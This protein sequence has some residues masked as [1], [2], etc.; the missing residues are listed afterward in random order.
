MSDWIGWKPSSLDRQVASSRLRC[1]IPMAEL[2]SRGF[3]IE[4]FDPRHAHRYAAVVYSKTYDDASY[5][6]AVKLR[7]A[8]IRIIFDLCDNHFYNPQNLSYWKEARQR[9][10][11]MMELADALVVSS[12]ALAEV[13]KR[14]LATQCSIAVIGDPVETDLN[15]WPMANWRRWLAVRQAAWLCAKLRAGQEQGRTPLIWFGNHGSPYAEGGMLDLQ[16]LG[17]LLEGLNRRSPISLTVISNSRWKYQRYI[18]PWRIPTHYLAWHP[19]TF[20]PLLREHVI[21]VIPISPNPFTW[22]KSNNRL[23]LALNEGVAVVADPIPSYGDFAGACC[24]GDW[25]T[26]LDSYLMDP[27][28]RR[29]HVGTARTII[30]NEWSISRIT[31]RWQAFFDS[32]LGSGKVTPRSNL[33]MGAVVSAAHAQE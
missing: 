27:Q 16:R 4:L 25:E 9:L 6:Q 3:L 23:A 13:V 14:E 26:G 10:T 19:A 20:L 31:D 29:S 1:L 22:C 32:F 11:R 21:A 8:G 7:R 15:N 30:R 24:L 2:Q 17:P 12:E 18:R 33:C 28:L 5:Q